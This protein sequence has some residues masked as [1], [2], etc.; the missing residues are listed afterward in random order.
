[1][2][3]CGCGSASSTPKRGRPKARPVPEEIQRMLAALVASST[4]SGEI[5]DV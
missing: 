3:R 4:A 1:M 2:K 5:V